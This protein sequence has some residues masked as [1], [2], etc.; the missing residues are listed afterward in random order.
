MFL[1][2]LI[3]IH[4]LTAI[5]F[6]SISTYFPWLVRKAGYNFFLD[7]SI[8]MNNALAAAAFYFTCLSLIIIH[9]S[10][11]LLLGLNI[12]WMKLTYFQIHFFLTVWY[13]T[14][15]DL[16]PSQTYDRDNISFWWISTNYLH[17]LIKAV[18]S[19]HIGS[20]CVFLHLSDAQL[21]SKQQLQAQP[22]I[23]NGELNRYF[24]A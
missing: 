5:V 17:F 15:V 14:T 3:K 23:C 11:Q 2:A 6:K 20:G 10:M 18:L 19:L 7:I 13:E 24:G 9:N 21:Y 8:N 22:K 16:F 4:R 1:L 12:H